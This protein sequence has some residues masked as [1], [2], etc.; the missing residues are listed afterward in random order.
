VHLYR[1]ALVTKAMY[2]HGR[3]FRPHYIEH[4]TADDEAAAIAV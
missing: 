2:L 3:V 1:V 4:F